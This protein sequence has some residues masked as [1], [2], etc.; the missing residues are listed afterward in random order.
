MPYTKGVKQTKDMTVSTPDPISNNTERVL[1]RSTATGFE[2]GIAALMG[3]FTAGPVG[4]LAS[5]GTL[6]G[7][8]GKWTPWF[9]LGIPAAPVLLVGQ[10]V[11]L[12]TVIPD[13]KTSEMNT[14]EQAALITTCKDMRTA[15]RTGD[16][17]AELAMSWDMGYQHGISNDVASACAN[18]G[19]SGVQN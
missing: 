4:A 16:A 13:T 17:Q 2:Q 5:W 14:S 8:Q 10:L 12:G 1:V 19:V 18:V 6:R 9:L 15:Q 11:V 3:F 7:L